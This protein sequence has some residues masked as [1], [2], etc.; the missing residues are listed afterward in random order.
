[1]NLDVTLARRKLRAR[2]VASTIGI[3]QTQLSLQ[4]TG[5]VKSVHFDTLSK[6]CWLLDCQPGDLIEYERLASDLTATEE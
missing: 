3:S 2:E 4:S 1:V 5:K 6:L